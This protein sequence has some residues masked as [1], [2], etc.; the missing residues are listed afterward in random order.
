MH[1]RNNQSGPT[2]LTMMKKKIST[3]FIL[4]AAV[5]G[6]GFV[7][8]G[9][10]AHAQVVAQAAAMTMPTDTCATITAADLV[11]LQAAQ[12][13]VNQE[14]ALRKKLLGQTIDCAT[15]DAQSLQVSLSAVSLVSGS[16]GDSI[17]SQLSGKL[18][19]A[20]NFYGIESAKLDGAGVRATEAIAQEMLAWRTANYI[21]LAGDVNDFVLWSENQSLFQTAQNRLTQT[22][23]VVAFIESAATTNGKLDAA[24][25]AAQSA[26]ADAQSQNNAAGLALSQ[27][28]PP[29]QALGLIQQSLQSL[30]TAY[31]KFSDLNGIIQ[32][33][34]PTGN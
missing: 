14:L 24:L 5:G 18:T 17:K 31:Q 20:I 15:Q 6:L 22:T 34:L 8:I 25:Q 29:D 32:T 4:I 21:P 33:L 10:H 16:N 13:D 7:G 9:E 12:G 3:V 26:F 11:S 28:Q 30:A 2:Q 23:R 1:F 19:D 27:V